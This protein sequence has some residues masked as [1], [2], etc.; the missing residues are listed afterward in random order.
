M[1]VLGFGRAGR[2][3]TDFLQRRGAA[4]TVYDEATPD[5]GTLAAYQGVGVRF[6][7]GAF[8]KRFSEGLLVRSPGIRPDHPAIAA[9]LAAGAELT[10]ETELF[11]R[12]CR[13]RIIG[14]TGSDGKT[15][16]ANLIA[17]LLRGAGHTAYLG[18]N[19]GTPLLPQVE[20]MTSH[21]F[22][23]LELSSF[24]LMT[25]ERSPEVGVITNIT[26]NHLNWHT[27]MTEYVAAKRR[28]F[29]H[30][31]KRLVI[32]ATLSALCGDASVPM[33]VFAAEENAFTLTDGTGAYR[34]P[35][36]DTFCLPGRHNREN[37][38]AAYAAVREAVPYDTVATALAG[39][40]GVPHRLQYVDTVAGVRY[41]NSSIDTSPTR[42]AAALTA[43]GGKPIV[44]AGGRGKGVSFSPLRAAFGANARAVV[45]YGEA[46]GEIERAVAGSVPTHRFD[47]FRT[48][49]CAAS[50][51]ARAGDT[52]LL[53]PAC[54]AFDQFRDFEE[55]GE[56]FCVLVRE[57]KEERQC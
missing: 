5:A 51:M 38:A 33:S 4:L 25:V 7:I 54:T 55:R 16:T 21:D 52:V 30:G 12:H 13:A 56:T 23:V 42:T 14:V 19:N 28:I 36:P 32:N 53:S 29:E 43:L 46:A 20:K 39:F 50:R 48:A 57:L 41:Y 2:A 18:G 40:Q 10:S 26:P 31:A 6:C 44:L 9:S 27:D 17:L 1:A 45:L 22:A 37:L 24:Q 34:Y 15:T 47:D 49:F 35:I 8:P 3:A 11:L